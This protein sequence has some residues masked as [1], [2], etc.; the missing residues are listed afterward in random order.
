MNTP[1]LDIAIQKFNEKFE[2]YK[3]TSEELRVELEKVI[4]PKIDK[5]NTYEELNSI[6]EWLEDNTPDSIWNFLYFKE[7]NDKL[8]NL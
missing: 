5:A 3:K 2:E 7:I 8:K 4:R 1:D 6:R